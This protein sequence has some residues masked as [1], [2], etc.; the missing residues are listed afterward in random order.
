MNIK[1]HDA[2]SKQYQTSKVIQLRYNWCLAVQHERGPRKPKPHAIISEK[3]HQQQSSIV[4][5][6]S[7]HSATPVHNDRLRP[8]LPPPYVL[9]PHR[10]VTFAKLFY[11]LN[12]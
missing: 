5:Q 12:C 9:S 7:P 2:I 1:L 10:C 6:L 11:K 3:Q 4:T 8:A